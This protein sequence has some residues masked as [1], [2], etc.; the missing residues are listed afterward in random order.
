MLTVLSTVRAWA[1][2]SQ[3][4]ACRNA[5]VALGALVERRAEREEVEEYLAGHYLDVPRPRDP[6]D[7]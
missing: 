7:V 2:A 4:R 1:V 5:T 3:N 6:S